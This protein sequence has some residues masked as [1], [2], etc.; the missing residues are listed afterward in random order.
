MKIIHPPCSLEDEEDKQ[1][2]DA[3]HP[4]S[5]PPRLTDVYRHLTLI[6]HYAARP[7]DTPDMQYML[8]RLKVLEAKELLGYN[9]TPL[10]SLHLI[11]VSHIKMIA[12][13]DALKQHVETALA[14]R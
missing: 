11:L 5:V 14:I 4:P 6:E 7:T 3:P 12:Q 9:R 2:I 1:N 10:H 8:A 13:V